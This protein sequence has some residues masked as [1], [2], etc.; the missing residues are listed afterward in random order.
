MPRPEKA[1]RRERKRQRPLM[2]VDGRG[3]LTDRPN[4]EKRKKRERKSRLTK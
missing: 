2:P 1:K 4:V 3:L